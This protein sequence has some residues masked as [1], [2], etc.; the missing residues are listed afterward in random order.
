MKRSGFAAASMSVVLVAMLV[1]GSTTAASPQRFDEVNVRRAHPGLRSALAVLN[2]NRTVEVAVQLTGQPVAV[3]QG[4]ALAGGTSLST[5]RKQELR[6]TLGNRQRV[7]AARLRG[8]G[9]R[10]QYTY[11]DVFNG[12]RIRVKAR[13]VDK[14][15]RLPNVEAVLTVPRHTIDNTSTV[16]YLGADRTWGQTGKTGAGVTIAIIDTGLNYYHADFGGAGYNAWKQDD[17]TTREPGTFPTAKVVGGYDLVGDSYDA[18]TQPVPHPDSDPLDCKAKDAESVQH[19]THVAGTAAGIGVTIAGETF[20]GSYDSYTL[21][22]TDFRIGP[23]VAPKAKLLAYRVFG[24]AGSSTVVVDA[25]ERAVQGGA[26]VINMSLGSSFGDAGSLDSVATDNASLA[27]VVVVASSGNSGA[28]AYLTGAPAVA[29]RAISVAAMDALPGYPGARLEMATGSDIRAIN[30]N[31]ATLNVTGKLKI[32]R[33]DPD[34]SVDPATGTGDESLGCNAADYTYNDFVDGQ[35][36]VVH[37]GI[38]ARTDRAVQGQKQ[39]AAAVIMVNTTDTLPPYEHPIAGVTI[40]FIGVAADDAD[41]LTANAGKSVTIKGTGAKDNPGYRGTAD[42]TSAGPRRADNAIKPDITAPGVSVFSADG[43]TTGQGKS[44]SGTSMASPAMAGVAA[45]IKQ[46]HPGWAPRDIKAAIVGTASAGKISPYD[47]RIAGSGLAQPRR[48]VDTVALVYTDPGASSLTFGRKQ[49]GNRPGTTTSFS[50]TQKLV[51]RNT[52]SRAI[53]Y[54]LSNSFDGDARGVRVSI[55]PRSV[56]VPAKSRKTIAVKVSLAESAVSGLPAAAPNH[57]PKL[58]VD[59]FGNYYT[60]VLAVGGVIVADPRGSGAGVYPLR[61]PWLVAPRGTSEVRQVDGSR[62]AYTQDGSRRDASVRFRNFGL[63]KGFVDVYAWGLTD[64]RDGVGEIDLRAAGVQSLDTA[65]CTGVPDSS[66]RC[67]VFAINTWHPW[68][69]AAADEFFVVIDVDKD[70]TADYVIDAVDDGLVFAGDFNGLMDALVIALPS[71]DLVGGFDAVVA[72]NGSTLLLPALASDFGLDKGG[73]TSF[74][75]WVESY[76]LAADSPQSDEMHT[77]DSASGASENAR[78]DVFKPSL[79]TG[80]FTPLGADK[81]TTVPLTVNTPTY[82]SNRGQ[83][84]W[85]VVTMD[86]ADG[87]D[88]ADM[89]VVGELP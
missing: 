79:S 66:D 7:V 8:L 10:I 3:R 83:K 46:A 20:S 75:Y 81:V 29:T 88:Q 22:T 24:C 38:C 41:Q 28:S 33:D 68:S 84:G 69:N 5:G 59:E 4:V 61:V 26:D 18:D 32:F 86:D 31:D 6:R 82:R 62:T 21:A 23:G 65:V 15:A 39:D 74:D 63:H 1:P 17:P 53:R 48:A 34:T 87:A 36:A 77:G 51:I 37:R 76:T 72:A 80:Y 16:P 2:G 71:G 50:E 14:I 49:A 44:L 12:F 27:G 40:P 47:L 56:I 25:I 19:G 30:A 45:L 52:S 42:F 67:L 73:I 55:S 9:A 35:V 58:A 54:D 85:L 57:A 64:G 13:N 43:G 11:T 70:G 78:F 60:P 89:V